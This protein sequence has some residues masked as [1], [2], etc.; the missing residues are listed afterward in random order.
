MAIF[1][2][3]EID[4]DFNVN[5]IT[6]SDGVMR[7]VRRSLRDGRQRQPDHCRRPAAAQPHPT[8]VAVTTRPTPGESIDVP[9]T[10]HGIA[11][12]PA[13]PEIRARLIAAA[14]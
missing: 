11:V 2:A 5:V 1:S 12:N 13:R 6:G 7:G 4:V 10:D 3:L 9:A 14:G 8:M